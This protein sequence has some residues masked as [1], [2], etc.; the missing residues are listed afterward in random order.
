MPLN[1]TQKAQAIDKLKETFS[2]ASTV[3]VTHYHGL[4]VK[5]MNNFR[6]S[7]RKNGAKVQVAKNTLAS[8]A[9]NDSGLADIQDLFKGPTVI[10]VSEDAV[11]AAKTVVDFA[12]ANEKLVILGGAY[13]GQA[14]DANGVKTLASTPS[15]DES[16]GRLVGLLQAPASQLLRLFQ[17]PGGQVARVLAAYA[18]KGE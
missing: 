11:A 2:G 9:A 13:N 16:R 15:L 7:A 8:A 5:D 6:A 10:T 14:L 1:R 12:K 3:V 18:E 4:S 17:T